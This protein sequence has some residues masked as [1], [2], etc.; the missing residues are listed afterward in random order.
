MS[1]ADSDEDDI[2]TQLSVLPPFYD[3]LDISF[4]YR[5]KTGDCLSIVLLIKFMVV[6]LHIF[7]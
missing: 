6:S 2:V 1:S 5:Y 3:F 4:H 7:C